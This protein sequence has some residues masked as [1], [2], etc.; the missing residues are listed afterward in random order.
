MARYSF[1][2]AIKALS[3]GV[4]SAVGVAMGG[5]AIAQS[6]ITPDSSLGTERS[7]VIPFVNGSSIDTVVGGR[8][9]NGNLLHSFRD[10]NVAE[11]RSV[12]FFSPSES[13]QT[14]FSRTTGDQPSNILGTLGTFGNSAPNLWLINPNGVFFGS[15]ARLDV[16]GA[17]MATTA[18]AVQIEDIGIVAA[19]EISNDSD[20]LTIDN[21]VFIFNHGNP[22]AIITNQSQSPILFLPVCR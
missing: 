12:Y 19:S 7:I 8:E 1:R 16:G 6:T 2:K 20:I 21:S 4:L 9:H 3:V 22:N 10:F 17:F 15:N 14:I 13:I 11:G 18:N 5:G